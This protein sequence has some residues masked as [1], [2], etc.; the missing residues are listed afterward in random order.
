MKKITFFFF[1]SFFVF[2]SLCAY[3]QQYEVKST[4]ILNPE[5]N[6]EYV[7][8]NADFWIEY[9][10][11]EDYGGFFSG[12]VQRDGTVN[13]LN[14]KSLIAQ[15]RQG[16]GMTRAFM[17]T[18][19]ETY[20]D[21]AES[22]LGFLFDYGWDN[23]YDGWYIQT[24]RQ[25]V[26][27]SGYPFV[28]QKWSFQQ[29]YAMV[30]IIA[31]Y[32]ATHNE[33]T[34]EFMDKGMNSLYENLWDATPGYEG[35][36]GTASLS[37]G[38]KKEKGFTPTVDAITTHAELIY[39]VTQEDQHK[40]RLMQLGDN[41]T[42]HFIS[43]MDENPTKILY[44]GE[45]DSNWNV[46]K[47]SSS[48]GHF[49]KTA[50]CLGRI[51][52]CDTSK[53]QYKEG[54]IKI[55]DK[56]WNY[57]NGTATLWDKENGGL[58]ES[59]T[60]EGVQT[61]KNKDYW[62]VEQGFTGPMINYYITKN[63]VYLQMAD[64][65]MDFF[66]NHFVDEEYGEIF[67]TLSADGETVIKDLKGDTYKACYHSIEMGYYGYLYSNLYYLFQPVD[68]YYKFEAKPEAQTITLTPIP[69]EDGVLKIKSVT[70]D[71]EDFT[72]FDRNTRTLNIAANQGGKFKVTFES[73][74]RTTSIMEKA[75]DKLHIKLY[76]NPTISDVTLEG[77]LNVSKISVVDITGK[78]LF[79]QQNTIDQTS[80]NISLQG[81]SSGV[82]FIIL[83]QT[84][85]EKSTHK[86]IKL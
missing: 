34:K 81:L 21:Y 39:L 56:S 61:A 82:Y 5:L 48:I 75:A 53:E 10:Y 40:N 6:I 2:F 64:E 7:R 54:A 42:D 23:T 18:G 12:D 4:H 80:A 60:Q 49:I 30:G 66:M 35:Y 38:N 24:N 25:G 11:D 43:W 76:P 28:D 1:F 19:D 17:M 52:L 36:Y 45:Y 57:T 79:E 22:A 37:W 78:L 51:Y 8:T 29:H 73:Y 77:L 58:F 83:H 14:V 26:R 16:Y 27:T 32:E 65:S 41:I 47:G 71:G 59:I 13:N 63:P 44:P 15:S 85:G 20:L 46:T 33:R 55:L 9:A 68:L 72:S 84:S 69:M 62:T 3:S 67:F 70:L 74:D 86:V 50:W 31:N